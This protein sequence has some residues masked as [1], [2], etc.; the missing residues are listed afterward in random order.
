MER[1]DDGTVLR[2][3]AR[4]VHRGIQQSVVCA[5]D[6][7]ASHFAGGS[8]DDRLVFPFAASSGWRASAV[9]AS[10]GWRASAVAASSGSR[11]SAVAAAA[12]EPLTATI[13]IAATERTG[14]GGVTS[15]SASAYCNRAC[16]ADWVSFKLRRVSGRERRRG[17]RLERSRRDD[18]LVR[19][20]LVRDGYARRGRRESRGVD[21]C[22]DVPGLRGHVHGEGTRHVEA[23]NARVVDIFG[24]RDGADD[25][26]GGAR[27][28]RRRRGFGGEDI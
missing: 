16:I 4:E 2:E 15:A 27:A 7:R 22:D 14:H 24:R 20:I 5:C 10:F 19:R 11:A 18:G 9:A 3:G 28:G 25:A 21:G 12:A 23:R 13:T 8:A 26:G 6:H 17:R 1:A